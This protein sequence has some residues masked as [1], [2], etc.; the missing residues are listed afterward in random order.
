MILINR[1]TNVPI[2]GMSKFRMEKELQPKTQT[3]EPTVKKA[4]MFVKKKYICISTIRICLGFFVKQM[5]ISVHLK[6]NMRSV[7]IGLV[8]LTAS[9]SC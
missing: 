5:P 3:E 2:P 4:A 9:M 7:R 1:E 8:I 6:W